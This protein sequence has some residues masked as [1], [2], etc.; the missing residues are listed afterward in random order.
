MAATSPATKTSQLSDAILASAGSNPVLYGA[1]PPKPEMAMVELALVRFEGS[2][3]KDARKNAV[4][5]RIATGFDQAR[6]GIPVV[7][8]RKNG[9]FY[10]IEGRK[11]LAAI[12]ERNKAIPGF[13][14]HVW[15]EV[16]PEINEK[17]RREEINE[18]A[19]REANDSSIKKFKAEY[20]AGDAKAADIVKI[21][22]TKGISVKGVGPAVG[23][24]VKCLSAIQWAY[25]HEVLERTIDAVGGA[26]KIDKK[27]LMV[28]VLMPVAVLIRKNEGRIDIAELSAALSQTTPKSLDS[29]AGSTN[30]FLRTVNI[31]N[32]IADLYNGRVPDAQKLERVG[33]SDT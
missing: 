1:E 21:L 19:R 9:F 17:A 22:A 16:V 31:A 8:K 4:F 13:M 25:D 14:T 5:Q 3:R 7:A 11:M 33:S 32:F 28:K 20:M 29:Q 2:D 23:V 24:G 6:L 30:G 15:C 18:K 27:T 26:W 10:P 12:M